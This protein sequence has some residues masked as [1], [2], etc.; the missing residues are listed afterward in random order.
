MLKSYIT[1]TIL[2]VQS[3]TESLRLMII[4]NQLSIQQKAWKH[5]LQKPQTLI[6]QNTQNFSLIL[7]TS[8]VI[9]WDSDSELQL[10]KKCSFKLNKYIGGFRSN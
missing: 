7:Q 4:N 5:Q 3:N 2:I 6:S 8:L 1:I 10:T 9:P